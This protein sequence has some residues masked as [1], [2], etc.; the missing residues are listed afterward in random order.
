MTNQTQIQNLSNIRWGSAKVEIENDSNVWVNLGAVK[1]VST[2]IDTK[3]PQKYEP[4]NTPPIEKVP[5][6]DGWNI[7]FTAEEVWNADVIKLIWGD[8]HTYTTSGNT[9]TIGLYAGTGARPERRIRLTNT[10]EGQPAAVIVLEKCTCKSELDIVY[11]KDSD[12]TTSNG[13]AVIFSAARDPL[14]GFGTLALS[15]AASVTISPASVSIEVAGT[16]QLTITGSPTTTTY[17]MMDI[18]VASVSS[19]GLITGVAAGTTTCLVTT[20]GVLHQIPVTV[21]GS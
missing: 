7:N 12:V 6:P 13:L 15:T 2:T 17:G 4:D 19:S 18:S 11:N 3:G 21:T 5:A 16:Q 8:I 9:T 10:T 20:D 14:T 1:N